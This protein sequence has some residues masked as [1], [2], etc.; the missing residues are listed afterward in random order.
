MRAE[1]LRV[2]SENTPNFVTFGGAGYFNWSNEPVLTSEGYVRAVI[3]AHDHTKQ[4]ILSEISMLMEEVPKSL[5]E[6]RL[7]WPAIT[8]WIMQSLM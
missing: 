8:E 3:T 7:K 1:S 6:A 5:E 4:Q 2:G